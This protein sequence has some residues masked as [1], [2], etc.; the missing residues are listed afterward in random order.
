MAW[1]VGKGDDFGFDAGA[2]AWADALNLSVVEGGE[3]KSLLQ[4]MV[5]VRV[6][7]GCPTATLGEGAA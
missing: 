4:D 2:I 3:R 6:G 7:E 1:A 5:C